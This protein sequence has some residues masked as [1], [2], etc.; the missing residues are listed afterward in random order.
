MKKYCFLIFS[1]IIVQLPC[2]GQVIDVPKVLPQSPNA[3]SLG[4]YGQVPVGLFTGTPQLSIPLFELNVGK[5]NL[6]ISLSYSSNGIRVDEIAGNVGLG[7]NLNAGGVITRSI[8]DEADE[9]MTLTLPN[10]FPGAR[11]Q[12]VLTFLENATDP[13]SGYDTFSDLYSFNFN[14]YSGSFYL[15]TSKQPVQI[16]PSPVK[17]VKDPP[18]PYSQYEFMIIDPNGITYLFGSTNTTE[19]SSYRLFNT[20]GPF[21]PTPFI[22]TSW[23]LSRI[24]SY[25]GDFIE[26]N[27]IPNNQEYI[28]SISQSV[29]KKANGNS[30]EN[31]IRTRSNNSA[32]L[33]N[34]ISSRNGNINFSYSPYAGDFYQ[35][36]NIELR[37]NNGGLIK[38][39]NLL[40]DV[41][42]SS[43]TNL[44]CPDITYEDEYG[45][46]LF[47]KS[48]TEVGETGELKQPY[49]LSYYSPDHIP[50]R[51]SYAQDYW[52]YYNGVANNQYLVSNADYYLAY[53]VNPALLHYVF[54]DIGGNKNPNGAFGKNG[55]LKK[56]VYPTGGSNEFL[57]ESHGYSGDVTHYPGDS[58][59]SLLAISDDDSGSNEDSATTPMIGYNNVA[60]IR[61][62]VGF[63][64]DCPGHLD[65]DKN[66]ATF[67]ITDDI[68]SSIAINKIWNGGGTTIVGYNTAVLAEADLPDNHLQVSLKE[69][70]V[71]TIRLKTSFMCTYSSLNFTYRVGVPWTTTENIPIGGLRIKEIITDD[72]NGVPEVRKY[73]YGDEDCLNCSSG[74]AQRPKT[75]INYSMETN[76]YETCYHCMTEKKT[77]VL[78]LTSS[79]V[80]NL[81]GKQ[82]H[83]IGYTSVIEEIGEDFA[84]GGISH[85]FNIVEDELPGAPFFSPFPVSG[86]P[87]TTNFGNGQELKTELFKKVA[88]EYVT[89]QKTVNHFS[90]NPALD[91]QVQMYGIRLRDIYGGI[92][93]Q[94][95]AEKVESYDISPYLIRSQWYYLDYSTT[96]E[97]DDNENPKAITTT[98]YGFGN[99]TH[100]Q[101]T[102]IV[103]TRTDDNKIVIT[104]T[105]Y[106]DDLLGDPYMSDL[107][108]D[109]Q[110]RIAEPI[111][112]RTY[113]DKGNGEELLSTQK[114]LY[115]DFGG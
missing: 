56:I 87:F 42:T 22:P 50:P 94:S 48:I 65:V 47:L 73:H 115:G 107:G 18:P 40:Y 49:T 108:S 59:I 24:E 105:D 16:N 101:P 74:I 112:V 17:I 67:Y 12:E 69:N 43:L 55:L 78:T 25:T 23:Y 34:S 51:F 35:L 44:K 95:V 7:W 89:V 98:S 113:Q 26:F 11:N 114:T 53:Q 103:T 52:G 39:Y 4:S 92:N 100:L 104:K 20:G 19:T 3:A 36:D 99:P 77:D 110:Y 75:A 57:Y 71:Y 30:T 97:Y 72:G 64:T 46:R 10:N 54:R 60:D 58:T 14:G 41:I 70:R 6:P 15:N 63:N 31:L 1:A 85:Q 79:T 102:R 8:N 45:K 62:N 29:V 27:Y 90:H 38:K 21:P 66:K 32:L 83:Q 82:G 61:F 2:F 33:L 88:D 80:N 9:S 93:Y 68:G 96:T 111:R 81:Y 86:T 13:E 109:G 28:S 106:P 37:K 91:H 5:I 84:G 76:Y